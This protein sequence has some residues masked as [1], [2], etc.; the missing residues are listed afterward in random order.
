M[1]HIVALSTQKQLFLNVLIKLL[2]QSVSKRNF[3]KL[4]KAL[5]ILYVA[6]VKNLKR[7][8][9]SVCVLKQNV[10]YLQNTNLSHLLF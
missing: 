1:K 7:T 3:L 4:I 8:C 2:F 9:I 6:D 10:V 5:I